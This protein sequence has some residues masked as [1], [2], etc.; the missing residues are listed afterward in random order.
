MKAVLGIC[1]TKWTCPN[2][3]TENGDYD[4]L[5]ESEVKCKK[6]KKIFYCTDDVEHYK[7][8]NGSE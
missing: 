2:C 1:T 4:D 5:L 3:N 7:E 8:R 6:C